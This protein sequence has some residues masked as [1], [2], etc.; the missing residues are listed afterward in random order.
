MHELIDGDESTM[1]LGPFPVIPGSRHI[2]ELLMMCPSELMELMMVNPSPLERES[3]PVLGYW[4]CSS[5]PPFT[6]GTSMNVFPLAGN[7]T[8]AKISLPS[9]LM[10]ASTLFK[11]VL[12][13]ED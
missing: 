8:I 13:E 3:S 5:L 11:I 1:F 12:E 9:R 4:N 10:L 2:S 6:N 7:P